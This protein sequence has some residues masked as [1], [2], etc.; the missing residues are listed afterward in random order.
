MVVLVIQ[1]RGRRGFL[2]LGLDGLI[3]GQGYN[4][5]DLRCLKTASRQGHNMLRLA[6]SCLFLVAF[7]A[8]AA[9]PTFINVWP[10]TPPG[11]TK[12][13]EPETDTATAKDIVGGR[14][15]QKITNVIRPTLTI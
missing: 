15:I 1:L 6:L 2:S 5:C 11:E 13:L 12:K 14:R 8:S 7:V 9:E 3:V 10:G 4:E